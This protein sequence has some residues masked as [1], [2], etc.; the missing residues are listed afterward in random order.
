MHFVLI[1]LANR[2]MSNATFKMCDILKYKTYFVNIG[3][4]T[5]QSI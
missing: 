3:S 1:G 2:M 5:H 4:I